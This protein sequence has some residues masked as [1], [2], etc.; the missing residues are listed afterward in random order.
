MEQ[1]STKRR[2]LRWIGKVFGFMGLLLVVLIAVGLV[3]EAQTLS[4]Y[5]EEYP[6][7]GEMVT[8][9]D[10]QLHLNC[11][12]EGSPT[13]VF[14]ADLDQYG[15][16][17]W[18]LVEGPVSRTTRTCVYDRAG[19]LWSEEGPRP[20]DGETIAAELKT[21]LDNAGETGPYVLVG[22][23]F[24]AVYLRIFA[25]QNPADVCGVVLLD[26]GHPDE[27]T[28]FAEVG[29]EKEIPDANI[30][31]LI[32][33]LSHLGMPERYS[34]IYYSTDPV[35]TVQQ[36]FLPVSSL[37]WYDESVAAP[38]TLAQ[39]A[40]YTDFGDLPLTLISTG[41][42]TGVKD[43]NNQDP[44]ELWLELQ[45]DLLS[46]S[47]NSQLIVLENAGH[48]LQYE[49]PDTVVAEIRAVVAACESGD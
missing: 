33:L 43:A 5:L 47:T 10:H 15:S 27:L 1:E 37:A 22:H 11:T 3:R 36:A 12:G 42:S 21:L 40:K 14:E 32:W 30:R 18:A 8:V 35:Y 7:R 41:H 13:V 39:A 49:D 28:R 19:I 6:P 45:N 23:A 16:L 34:G 24:G 20:R 26:S 46:L 17:S 4:R 44:L 29:I 2:V 9:G 31:P 25:G 48:Y 38:D